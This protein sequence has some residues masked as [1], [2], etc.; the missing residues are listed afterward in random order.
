MTILLTGASG[1]LGSRIYQQLVPE[2]SMTTVGRTA[3]GSRHIHCDLAAQVP[4]LPGSQ[5]DLV[6]HAAGKANA[7]PR[8]ASE[9]ADYQRVNVQGTANLLSALEKLP[10]PPTAF[11]HLSTVLVYGCSSGQALRESTPLLATDPYGASKVEAEMLLQAWATRTGVRLA[12][13]R[14]PLVVAEPLNGNLATLQTAIR[15]GYYV[16]IGNGLARRSMVRADDVAAVLTRVAN[17]GGTFNLTDGYH[18]TVRELEDAIARKLGRKRP[19][20]S[21]PLSLINPMARLGDGINAV[22]GRRFPID[23]IALQKLTS[24]L[25]FSD[26]RARQQLDWRPRPVLDLLQ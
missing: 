18:P 26:E 11:V 12:I 4:D 23:S 19:I 9:R 6:I 24:T 17:V 13:L 22:I 1:F 8:T 15:R 3:C 10:S 2:H 21:V 5:F 16:R 7:V 25:T 20:P 14:L